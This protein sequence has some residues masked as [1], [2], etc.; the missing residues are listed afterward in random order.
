[1][2]QQPEIT[3]L[4]RHAAVADSFSLAPRSQLGERKTEEHAYTLNNIVLRD[5]EVTGSKVSRSS[6]CAADDAVTFADPS[7]LLASPPAGG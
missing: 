4:G 7:H 2:P 3:G 5:L 1:M 6:P